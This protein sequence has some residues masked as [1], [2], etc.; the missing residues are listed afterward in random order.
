MP[1]DANPISRPNL[2]EGDRRLMVLA[3]FLPGIPVKLYRMDRWGCGTVG[4]AMHWAA[5]I[6]EFKALGYRCDD[7]PTLDDRVGFDAVA[8]L[9]GFSLRAAWALFNG[10]GHANETPH[11]TAAR[12]RAFVAKRVKVEG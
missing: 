3:E 1:F 5:Q 6:P 7:E 12:L 10:K 9:F 4:C 2:S 11:E 8:R